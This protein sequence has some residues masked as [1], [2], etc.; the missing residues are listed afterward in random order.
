VAEVSLL[1]IH[2]VT[3]LGSAHPKESL[4]VRCL[5]AIR[6]EACGPILSTRPLD[7][8][9]N[10]PKRGRC[11]L[12]SM[13]V[14]PVLCMENSKN[15][16]NFRELQALDFVASFCALDR[17]HLET[18]GCGLGGVVGR[19]ARH[20]DSILADLTRAEFENISRGPAVALVATLR[21]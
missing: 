11:P 8:P 4:E 21:D 13:A 7:V 5:G 19:S 3:G 20:S 14:P 10:A 2:G 18:N 6:L 15:S 12:L 9:L 1:L 17:L 16:K